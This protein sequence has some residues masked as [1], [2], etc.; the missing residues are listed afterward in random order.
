MSIEVWINSYDIDESSFWDDAS[1]K[2]RERLVSYIEAEDL[3]D[4]MKYH[5][6][7]QA[8]MNI[9]R[10]YKIDIHRLRDL[11]LTSFPLD[12]KELEP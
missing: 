8:V 2:Q 1:E 9:L 12:K 4:R 6:E 5:L 10:E 11:I 3:R 7:P